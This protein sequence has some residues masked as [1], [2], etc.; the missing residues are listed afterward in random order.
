VGSVAN[1]Q[2]KIVFNQNVS[3]ACSAAPISMPLSSLYPTI[4]GGGTVSAADNVYLINPAT[5]ALEA[6]YYKT[7]LGAGWKTAAGA[8][9]DATRDISAGYLVQRKSATAAVLTQAKTW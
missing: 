2:A 8:T 6:F 7:G 1:E 9:A 4:A 3:S 5:G